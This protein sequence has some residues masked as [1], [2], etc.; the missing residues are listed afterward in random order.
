M[1]LGLVLTALV[2]IL[3]CAFAADLA[4]V[5]APDALRLLEYTIPGATAFGTEPMDVQGHAGFKAAGAIGADKYEAVI[6]AVI[7]RVVSVQKNGAE[8]YKWPGIFAVG[9]RGTVRFAPENTI[10][11]YLKAID[12]GAHIVEIDVRETKDGQ[13]VIMH[14]PIVFRTTGGKGFVAALTLEEIKKLDAGA[15]FAPEFA[16]TPVPTLDEVLDALAGKGLPDID[17]KAG[18]PAK[19]VAAL[20]AHG[21]LGKAS[22][23]NDDFA[24]QEKVVQ[25]GEGKVLIRPILPKTATPVADLQK[26]LNPPLV[27]T[28]N[29]STF[30]DIHC[31]GMKVWTNTMSPKEEEETSRIK[32]AIDAYADYIQTDRLDILVPLLK[33]RGLYAPHP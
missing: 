20:R 33:E 32:A 15:K 12:L 29:L 2:L 9:H 18:D 24:V 27:N 8:Q 5:T 14:D 11:A 25:C 23:A 6:D 31:A 17:F 22:L 19:V 21:L 16:G 3:P 30:R 1:R 26:R 4:P 7:P 10:P 13:I 28:D